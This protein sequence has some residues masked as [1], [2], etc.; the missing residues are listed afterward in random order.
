MLK[1]VTKELKKAISNFEY[2]PMFREEIEYIL[3]PDKVLKDKVDSGYCINVGW[4]FQSKNTPNK[5]MLL[6]ERQI[7]QAL[8]SVNVDDWL[9]LL[10]IPYNADN[11]V[12]DF[13]DAL[14]KRVL[15]FDWMMKNDYYLF[16]I[17]KGI[18][19]MFAA[20]IDTNSGEVKLIHGSEHIKTTSDK[21]AINEVF[22]KVNNAAHGG[23]DRKI[24]IGLPYEMRFEKDI[25]PM[26]ALIHQLETTTPEETPVTDK[27]EELIDD[28]GLPADQ[29]GEIS[30][31]MLEQNNN[32]AA[33]VEDN[34]GGGGYRATL[35]NRM[36][37]MPQMIIEPDEDGNEDEEDNDQKSN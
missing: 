5:R 13:I 16:G 6:S 28:E 3:S 30:R 10:K 7:G 36:R 8:K 4:G 11:N 35:R 34:T 18:N 23:A 32:L 31:A 33:L 9:E 27:T 37:E 24:L 19:H 1:T 12:K 2:Y 17:R 20:K 22:R 29:K 25:K 15:A 14:K 21:R 26:V